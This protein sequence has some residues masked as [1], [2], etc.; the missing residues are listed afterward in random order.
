MAFLKKITG[1]TLGFNKST[2]LDIVM[3]DKAKRHPLYRVVGITT[4]MK[5]GEGDN[6]PWTALTGMFIATNIVTGE[7]HE[8]AVAFLPTYITEIYAGGLAM[9][10]VTSVNVGVDVYA[11][12]EEESATS[13][14]YVGELHTQGDKSAVE[15]LAASLP[16]IGKLKAI[17]A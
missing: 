5:T 10:G 4:G 9:E 3:G 8:S 6:G 16:P 12:F 11:R 14:E 15:E 13:Y 7:T 2:V 17:A 1:K